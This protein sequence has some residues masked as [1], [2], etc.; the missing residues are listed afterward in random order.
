MSIIPADTANQVRLLVLYSLQPNIANP[1]DYLEIGPT[2]TYDV[3]SFTY[4]YIKD[5][6]VEVLYDKTWTCVDGAVSGYVHEEFTVQLNKVVVYEA[7]TNTSISGQLFLC[8]LS[9][10]NAVPNPQVNLNP[11]WWYQDL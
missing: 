3:L 1:F 8:L 2:S 6:V 10:S 4:P 5:Q 11:K 7:G 9:D